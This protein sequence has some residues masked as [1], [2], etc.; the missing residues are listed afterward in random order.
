MS[1]GVPLKKKVWLFHQFFVAFSKYMNFHNLEAS[2]TQCTIRNPK[3]VMKK[4]DQE[5]KKYKKT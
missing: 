3:S 2:R 1:M 5:F 4:F